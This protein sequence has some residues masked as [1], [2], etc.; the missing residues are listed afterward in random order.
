MV[1]WRRRQK[2]TNSIDKTSLSEPRTDGIDRK[3]VDDKD[4]F[5]SKVAELKDL[6]ID[7]P[8]NPK[9]VFSDEER[10]RKKKTYMKD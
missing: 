3:K 8:Q 5:G 4:W 1:N 6:M 9:G 2:D 10:T 7:K